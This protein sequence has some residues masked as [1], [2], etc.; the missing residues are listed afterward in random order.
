LL[1][2]MKYPKF[3][4]ILNLMETNVSRFSIAAKS[5]TKTKSKNL[6]LAFED[7]KNS[8]PIL[9]SFLA[10]IIVKRATE[11]VAA[12]TAYN[13]RNDVIGFTKYLV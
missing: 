1:H 10:L 4:M 7:K 11:D 12:L 3:P 6:K 9:F 2:T 8:H 13:L 5:L